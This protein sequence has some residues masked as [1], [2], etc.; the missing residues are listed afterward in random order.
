MPSNTTTQQAAVTNLM[1]H[2]ACI[3][4]QARLAQIQASIFIRDISAP[5]CSPAPHRLADPCISGAAIARTRPAWSSPRASSQ[6]L[7]ARDTLAR[8]PDPPEWCESSLAELELLP[9]LAPE[10]RPAFLPAA[11]ASECRQL[12]AAIRVRTTQAPQCCNGRA[13]T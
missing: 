3:M 4:L 6:R 11:A 12:N 9:V 5:A 8:R 7:A 2:L 13:R 10:L 1:C